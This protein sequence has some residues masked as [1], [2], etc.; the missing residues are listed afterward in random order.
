M[1][2]SGRSID[3]RVTDVVL[4]PA[5]YADTLFDTLFVVCEIWRITPTLYVFCEG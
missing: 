3:I 2:L 4:N 5:A 1:L